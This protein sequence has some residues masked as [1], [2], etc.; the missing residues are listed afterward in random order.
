MIFNTFVV[1]VSLSPSAQTVSFHRLMLYDA[2]YRVV[3]GEPDD[4]ETYHRLRVEKAPLVVAT[5]DDMTNTSVAFNV[6]ETSS[7]VPIVAWGY[8]CRFRS[9][10]RFKKERRVD[11]YGHNRG[12]KGI[13]D[14][15]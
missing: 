4:P 10:D 2:G 14:L 3:V 9:Y 5:S 6:R 1:C 15:F 13:S 12:G 8:D 7:G 11:S